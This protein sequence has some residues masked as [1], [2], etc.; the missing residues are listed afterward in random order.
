MNRRTKIAKVKLGVV[1]SKKKRPVATTVQLKQ[2]WRKDDPKPKAERVK[3]TFNNQSFNPK[4]KIMIDKNTWI[5]YNYQGDYPVHRISKADP[6]DH[7]S[8]DNFELP[9]YPTLKSIVSKIPKDENKLKK[10]D[11][12]IIRDVYDSLIWNGEEFELYTS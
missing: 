12:F 11:L 3:R 5:D 10:M 1:N 7:I 8:K 4:G 9:K 6:N 2:M